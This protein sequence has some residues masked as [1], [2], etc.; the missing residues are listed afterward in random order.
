MTEEVTQDTPEVEITSDPIE[1]KA[2]SAG[3]KP[4]EEWDGDPTEWRDAKTFVDR[5]ELL[6]KIHQQ[7]RTMKELRTILDDMKNQ[8]VTLTKQQLGAYENALKNKRR[9]YIEEG[10]SAE[11]DKVDRMIEEVKK[12]QPQVSNGPTPSEQQRLQE[13]F[14]NFKKSNPWFESDSELTSEANQISQLKMQAAINEYQ[15]ATGRQKTYFT[16]EEAEEIF[17][18]VSKEVRKRNPNKF[19]N[20]KKTTPPAV[21]GTERVSSSSGTK[22]QYT[23]RDV[24]EEYRDIVKSFTRQGVMTVHEYVES[25]K[26][27]GVI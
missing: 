7:N 13:V 8:V 15:Q 5:G 6:N 10:N 2:R 9:E 1:E 25:L 26:A 17:E 11:V 24:P 12:Q 27:Q 4:L 21:E 16:P 23:M 3:W 20:Q 14:T 22:K 18:F 19:K